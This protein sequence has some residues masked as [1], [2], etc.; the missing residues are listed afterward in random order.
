MRHFYRLV[1]ICILSHCITHIALAGSSG[2]IS[3]QVTDSRTKEGIAGVNVRIEGTTLGAT[4]NV[5]GRYVILNVPPGNFNVTASFIGYKKYS[6][7]G[8]RVSTDFTTTLDMAL[9]EGD[10]QTDEVVV[11]GERTPLIRKDLTNPVASISA[12]TITELPVTEIS[13]IIGLQ[14]GITVDDGGGLHVRGGLG[15][16]IAYTINGININNPYGNT[17]SVGL[18]TNAVQE[19]SVSSGTFNAEYGNALSGV[20]NYVTKE[21]GSNWTGSLKHLTGDHLSTNRE[22]FF[23]IDKIN[24]TNVNRTEASVGG[25]IIGEDLAFY[26]SGVYSWFGG[27]L[28]GE[29]LYNPLD[30]FLAPSAFPSGDPR[31]GSS[32]GPLYFGAFFR[33]TSDRVGGPTGNR[34]VVPLNWSRSYN[35][36]GN[37]RYRFTPAMRLKYEIVY[38]NGLS[39]ASSSI[40]YRFRPDGRA[41]DRS[42]TIFHSLEWLQSLGERVF[43]TVKG[44]YI[45]DKGRSYTYD[46]INDPRYL[47]PQ[48]QTTLPN[49]NFLTG[50]TDLG[51]FTR[52]STM[53]GAK[54]DLVAQLFGNHEV[55]FGAEVRKHKVDVES[56]TLR[57]GDPN[58]R[59]RSF[60]VEDLVRGAKLQ[61]FVPAVNEGYTSYIRRPLQL[62]TYVQDK[63]ELF[64]SIILNLGLRYEYFDPDAKYNPNLSNEYLLGDSANFYADGAIK[65]SIKHMLAPRF[66]VSYPI[67]D[68]G[69]IRFSYGHFYQIGSLSSLYTNPNFRAVPG[70]T[71]TFGNP[72]V[73]PQRSIQYELGLQQAL[74]ENLKIEV[75]GYYKDVDNYIVTQRIETA[76]GDKP[77]NLLTNLNYANTRGIA[78]SLFKRRS[79]SDIFSA[80]IDYTFQIADGNRTEP[81]SEIFFNEQRGQLSETY[82]VP[83]SFDRSHTITSTITF[84]QPSDWSI[85]VLGYVRMGTPYTPAF[86]SNI[87]PISFVQNSDRQPMQWNVDLKAEKFFEFGPFKYSVFLQ[88]DNLFDTQNELDVYA[89]S[90]S[91]LYDINSVVNPNQYADIRR[92]IA[93]GDVGLISSSVIDNLD[94]NPRNIS[95]PRLVRFGA[96][97]FF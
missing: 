45:I 54:F 95:S 83:F 94:A 11:Q 82:L 78:I 75:T 58:N 13:E 62:V 72:E 53:I 18:A 65:A 14:A 81:A 68:Q 85:G 96:S 5:E 10:I 64:T 73:N 38:D 15:N 56:Y 87:V 60:T 2:K 51:R 1:S 55:K 67:T 59:S 4:T 35:L 36:Q 7:K 93:R 90:G 9:V 31:R 39:P 29:R 91:A 49:T 71:P 24:W 70:T 6:V 32:T 42:E 25:P 19:V 84:S 77:Y 44:S 12:E 33:D 79:P 76:R 27:H 20:V 69:T 37:L 89:S 57:F 47:P 66:S 17:R 8:V 97:I 23:N 74:T 48:Y 40:A 52:N 21:G 63:I 22:L 88:V 34:D 80:T 86:P 3:G 61:P 41:L 30:A 92:R 43:Y 46:D 26:A 28:Y 50:G 16:E